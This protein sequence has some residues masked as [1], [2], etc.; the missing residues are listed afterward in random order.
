[1]ELTDDSSLHNTKC[2]KMPKR[3]NPNPKNKFTPETSAKAH[4][5]RWSKNKWAEVRAEI[6][7]AFADAIKADL[8][9]LKAQKVKF[10]REGN[11]EGVRA[12]DEGLKGIGAHYDN[13]ERAQNL[14]IKTE[15]KLDST[16][17]IQV[18]RVADERKG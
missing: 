10:M 13:E 15:G 1:M 12:I 9:A 3:G 6:K 17:S 18:G 14:N 16:L 7:E 8:K 11:L 2:G 4:E 5:A